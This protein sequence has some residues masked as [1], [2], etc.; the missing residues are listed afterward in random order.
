MTK[1]IFFT[2]IICFM[3]FSCGKK[4]DP[5]YEDSNKSTSTKIISLNKV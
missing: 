3:I 1:K 2:L 4:S 5:V